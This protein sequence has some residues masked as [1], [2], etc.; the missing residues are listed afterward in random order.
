MFHL[1]LRPCSQ[2]RIVR[3][4]GGNSRDIYTV[5][6]DCQADC[7]QCATWQSCTSPRP[8]M[9][10]LASLRLATRSMPRTSTLLRV[11][12]RR[13]FFIGSQRALRPPLLPPATVRRLSATPKKDDESEMQK[14]KPD[15]RAGE[16][17][18]PPAATNFAG[19]ELPAIVDH[20]LRGVGQ[21]DSPLCHAAQRAVSTACPRWRSEQYWLIGDRWSSATVQHRAHWSLVHS[22]SAP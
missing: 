18:P 10:T 20:N 13:P 6:A 16:E 3:T 15:E 7:Q 12:H 19:F 14:T 5:D 22:R 1:N 11:G 8:P 9:V 17:T 4:S 2:I 21:V